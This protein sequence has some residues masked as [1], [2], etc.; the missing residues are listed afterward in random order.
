MSDQNT[1]AGRPGSDLAKKREEMGLS[2]AMVAQSLCLPENYVDALEKNDW[3]VL[4]EITFI[5]GYIRS[6]ARFVGL[7][8]EDLVAAFEANLPQ[9][10]PVKPR[11][12]VDVDPIK[13]LRELWQKLEEQFGENAK[14]IPAAVVLLIFVLI[15]L[16]SSGGDDGVAAAD[17]VVPAENATDLDQ[18][19]ATSVQPDIEID[20]AENVLLS[21]AHDV[22]DSEGQDDGVAEGSEIEAPILTEAPEVA[23]EPEVEMLREALL[24]V[25]F[26]E[27][28]WYEITD[29]RGVII[30]T[31]VA[32]QSEMLSLSVKT[33]GV[34]K[35]GNA[36]V[37]VVNFDS[38]H[39]PTEGKKVMRIQLR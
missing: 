22:V 1:N 4:P 6:Y 26:N 28:C 25:F 31:G 36:S 12:Q 5:R 37:A 11:P 13:P 14:F 10:E 34:L 27:E 17:S 2:Q 18:T 30:K 19:N 21:D 23:P 15:L 24:E 7:D 35:L 39:L 3:E 38:Q 9:K 20:S 8:Q 32:Q 33:P 29:F 16:L